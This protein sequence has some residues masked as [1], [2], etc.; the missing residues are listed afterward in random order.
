MGEVAAPAHGASR[1]GLLK[2]LAAAACALIAA[3]P[4]ATAG[5]IHGAAITLEGRQVGTVENIDLWSDYGGA[6]RMNIVVKASFPDFE[7]D[8]D[9][10]LR[11]KGL[12]QNRCSRRIQWVG[13]TSIRETGA[14]LR[15]SSRVR[16]EQW[17]CSSLGNVRLLS[18][19]RSVHW[20]MYATRA[21]IDEVAVTA[22]LDDIVDFPDRMERM[23]GLRVREQI[24]IP[25]PPACGKCDCAKVIEWLQPAF[26]AIAFSE[27]GGRMEVTTTFSTGDPWQ[28]MT[29]VP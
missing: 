13:G 4:F 22:T 29:C 10:Y 16:Y 25:L 17:A 3:C 23:F 28:A 24:P 21:P 1:P 20:S 15:L 2:R 18:Q 27:R 19:T 12:F 11:G 9:R 8:L 7:A 26:E 14:V 6:D 5:A